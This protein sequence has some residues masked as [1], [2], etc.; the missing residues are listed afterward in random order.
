MGINGSYTLI[1]EF[2]PMSLIPTFA[3]PLWLLIGLITC[4][5]VLLFILLNSLRR[6]KE[7]ENFAAPKL[8]TGLTG[9][10]S[11]SRRR[12]KNILFVLGVAFL[13]LA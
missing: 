6:K 12:L 1:L 10:V 4:L 8:L 2:V 13:F 7:L 3:D 9:N 11:R 5:A